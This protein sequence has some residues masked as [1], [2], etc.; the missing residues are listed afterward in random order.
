MGLKY[1]APILIIQWLNFEDMVTKTTYR[2][3]FLALVSIVPRHAYTFLISSTTD[4]ILE[5]V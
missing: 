3:R 4:M 1:S 5:D 2:R